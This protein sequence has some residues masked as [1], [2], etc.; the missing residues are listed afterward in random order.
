[1]ALPSEEYQTQAH[2]EA[3]AV[4]GSEALLRALRHHHDFNMYPP[5][6]WG[7]R[8]PEPEPIYV[9]PP[10]KEVWFS[11][12]DPEDKPPP[13]I[14][15]I[16]RAACTHFQVSITDLMSKRR[17]KDVV[18][19]RHIAFFL[20]KSRTLHSLPEIGRRFGGKDHTTVL[21][22]VRK[23]QHL[24]KTDWRVAYDVAHVEGML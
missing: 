12:D 18:Y 23:I 4:R 7:A 20:A 10:V 9:P 14:A 5:K 2:M 8:A 11:F 22:G 3:D 13:K 24:A 15:D 16:K 1:M 21:H 17:T 6:G 19:P